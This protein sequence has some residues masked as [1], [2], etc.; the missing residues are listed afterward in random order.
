M[1]GSIVDVIIDRPLNSS[2]PEYNDIIYKVNYGYIPNTKSDIDGE[3]I[4]AY[5]IDVNFPITSYH[6]KVIGIIH[7]INEEDKLIVANRLFNKEEIWQKVSFIEQ[8][9]ESWLEVLGE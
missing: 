1:L 7:R 3:E 6:G 2:H 5:I 4:D 9:F 8:Y